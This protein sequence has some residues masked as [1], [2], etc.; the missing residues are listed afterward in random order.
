[1]VAA[2][3]GGWVGHMGEVAP[4]RAFFFNFFLV[5]SMRPQLALK[6][7]DFR[8]MYPEMCFR[9][10]CVPLGSVFPGVTFPLLPPKPFFN[11]ANKAII[12]HG[13]E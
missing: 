3:N 2:E 12:L 4:S 8:S 13:N 11:G 7:V 1:M 5:P 9:G 10:G 6:S